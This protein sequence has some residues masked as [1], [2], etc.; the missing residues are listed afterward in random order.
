MLSRLLISSESITR[1]LIVTVT[2][3]M[4]NT[5]YV[6]SFIHFISFWAQKSRRDSRISAAHNH[7]IHSPPDVLEVFPMWVKWNLG[8]KMPQDTVLPRHGYGWFSLK[9]LS[10]PIPEGRTCMILIWS[11][12]AVVKLDHGNASFQVRYFLLPQVIITT[13]NVFVNLFMRNIFHTTYFTVKRL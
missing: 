7:P 10:N 1:F 8:T 11:F 6:T 12:L 2:K 13:A 3:K 4:F 9:L 5:I